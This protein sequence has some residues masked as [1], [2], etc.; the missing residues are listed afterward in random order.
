MTPPSPSPPSPRI[1]VTSLLTVTL[2]GTIRHFGM[3]KTMVGQEAI[4]N[5]VN[6]GTQ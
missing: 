3:K 4:G 1:S 2:A 6:I 5:G